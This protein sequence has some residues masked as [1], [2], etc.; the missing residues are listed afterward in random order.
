[1]D[2]L[3][4]PTA[5]KSWVGKLN[6]TYNIGPGYEDDSYVTLEV[7]TRVQESLIHN[8]IGVIRGCT[9][10]D[11]Y[12]LVGNHRDSWTFGA[13]DPSSGTA[14]MLEL[15][16]AFTNVM[17]NEE[18]CPRRTIVFCSW[19]AEEYGLI[20]STEWVEENQKLLQSQAVAY[21]NVDIAVEGN[22]SLQA[23]GVPLLFET[24]WNAAKVVP[25]PNPEEVRLGRKTVYDTWIA[26]SPSNITSPIV[27]KVKG[28][29]SGSDHSPFLQI[30]GVPVVDF[31]YT[32]DKND[33]TICYPLYH[34]MYETYNL[35]A[36]LLDRGF[37]VILN[38]DSNNY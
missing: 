22:Y 3:K 27:P 23:N 19:G 26:R 1:M 32:C 13:V 2:G 8:V 38:F 9:E 34:T 7:Y 16:K 10:P 4:G 18:W 6:I 20:G 12:V 24:I 14:A 15:T 36:N 30:V 29:G 11:R 28:V 33:E 35:E 37:L 25:N 21:L 5:P 17:K 31:R